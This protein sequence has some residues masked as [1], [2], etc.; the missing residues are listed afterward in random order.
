MRPTLLG[1]TPHL[2]DEAAGKLRGSLNR[3][4]VLIVCLVFAP[5]ILWLLHAA[6][7]IPSLFKRELPPQVV[8]AIGSV[9]ASIDG[10]TGFMIDSK[11]F[12][13]TER[14]LKGD[15]GTV[16]TDEGVKVAFSDGEGI[17]AEAVGGKVVWISEPTAGTRL[18]MVGMDEERADFLTADAEDLVDGARFRV[19]GFLLNAED[20]KAHLA[21]GSVGLTLFEAGLGSADWGEGDPPP[22]EGAP[23]VRK[24]EDDNHVVTGILSQGS[25]IVK[26]PLEALRAGGASL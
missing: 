6:G 1:I 3:A 21:Q 18:V 11:H 9:E 26:L 24:L 8:G 16:I 25:L 20:G 12:L 23:V 17:P 13:T 4:T 7:T 2:H 22:Y 10:A 14:A 5:V 19:A 15:G